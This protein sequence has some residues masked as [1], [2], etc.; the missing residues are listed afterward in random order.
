MRALYKKIELDDK[1]VN[2]YVTAGQYNYKVSEILSLAVL[3]KIQFIDKSH[4][5]LVQKNNNN[6]T[7][8]A[9]DSSR[10]LLENTT[11]GGSI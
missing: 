2:C 1:H 7:N 3:Q 4:E 5:R 9:G 6:V 10:A 11:G 8:L